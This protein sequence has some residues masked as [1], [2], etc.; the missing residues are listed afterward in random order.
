MDFFALIFVLILSILKPQEWSP[1]FNELHPIQLISFLIIIALWRKKGGFKIKDLFQT[2]HHWLVFAYFAW[3]VFA[4]PTPWETFKNIQ[5]NILFF[6]IAVQTLTTIPRLLKFMAWWA[7]LLMTIVILA[8]LTQ[9]GFDPF[10]SRDIIEW[11]M[12]GRLMLNIS[13]FNNPN[14]L[15]HGVVPLIPMLFFLLFWKRIM[16]KAAAVVMVLP[17]LCIFLTQSKGAFL[18]GFATLATI[19]TFGRPK[20]IQALLLIVCA[21]VGI[22]AL[23][24]LPRMG[25]LSKS[26]TDA[27]IQGRIAA[28]KFALQ[29]MQR[30]WWGN[31]WGNF[32]PM[33]YKYGPMEPVI[34]K[35]IRRRHTTKGTE[36][37]TVKKVIHRHYAKATH[38]AYYQ[39]GADLGFP[40]LFLFVGILYSC[41]RT[42][43][44][45]K[46]RD[47]NEE[48]VRRIL[49]SIVV[50]FA[51]SCWMVDFFYR[52]IF[53]LFAAA[54][55][56]LHIILSKP[57]NEASVADPEPVLTWR[58][59]IRAAMSPVPGVAR[60]AA[61]ATTAVAVNLRQ[62]I[63]PRPS[64]AEAGTGIPTII[65]PVEI[66]D[67]N[68]PTMTWKRYGVLDFLINW[69]L[70]LLVIAYWKHI[71]K[72][73]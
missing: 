40:G 60:A 59:Q 41:F 32:V 26:K 25:E 4:S 23:Y 38:G 67:M 35:E 42:L 54:T 28:A 5:G 12:K 10:G 51:V 53:F 14:A 68:A 63:P 3:T 55:A 46:T 50:S 15:A 61:A 17:L 30:S 18:C 24:S 72:T 2:P 11:S 49:F 1:T 8:L 56:A 71:I 45:A 31:G 33:F 20:A 66:E 29:C 69:G 62:I 16:M 58:D 47:N 73:M 52:T 37:V 6:V 44:Q 7:W 19:L 70:T 34:V 27:A 13:I 65:R 48:R 21:T 57:K 9:V 39:N 43:I 36:Y 64:P 22:T